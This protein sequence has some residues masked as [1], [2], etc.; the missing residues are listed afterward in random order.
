MVY[1]VITKFKDMQ[2]GRIYEIGETYDK[3]LSKEREK[4][5]TTK[6]N[7]YQTVFIKSVKT[8]DDE[9]EEAQKEVSKDEKK[10]IKKEKKK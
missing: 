6:D 4:A 2:E 1:E 8:E 7:A 9:D 10:E 5:L 3:E